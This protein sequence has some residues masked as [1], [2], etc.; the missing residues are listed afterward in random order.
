MYAQMKIDCRNCRTVTLRPCY[1][2]DVDVFVRGDEIQFG[3]TTWICGVCR[4]VN[5]RTVPPE[6]VKVLLAAGCPMF[7]TD[8]PIP[9]TEAEVDWFTKALESTDD[10]VGILEATYGH[11]E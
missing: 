2:V 1:A 8:E 7:F 6:L 10:I 3:V 4:T 5:S 9:I 11:R